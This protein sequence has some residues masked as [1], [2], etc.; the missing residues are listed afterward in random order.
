MVHTAVFWINSFLRNEGMSNTVSPQL[1]MAGIKLT[2][3]HAEH[4]FREHFQTHET[5]KNDMSKRT[6]DATFLGLIS[7]APGGFCALNLATGE[8]IKRFKGTGSP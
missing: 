7:D 4:N 8:Q 6:T 1:M 3:T 5:L 2:M